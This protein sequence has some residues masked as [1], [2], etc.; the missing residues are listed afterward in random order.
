[1]NNGIII[2]ILGA[3]IVTYLTRFPLM[4]LSGKKIP[5]PLMKYLSFIAPA[6]LTA[7]IAPMIFIKQGRVDISLSNNYFI[8]AIITVLVSYFS[9]NMLASLIAGI[10]SVALLALIF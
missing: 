8:A 5:S 2:T 3:A 6:V 1:M 10:C 4:I 7:L 9:K